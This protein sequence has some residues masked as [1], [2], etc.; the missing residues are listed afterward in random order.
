MEEGI[1]AE[2]DPTFK[3]VDALMPFAYR[4]LLAQVSPSAVA[5]RLERVG[6]TSPSWS[7]T[8]RTSST[9]CSGSSRAADS[10]FTCG[11]RSYSR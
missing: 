9:G 7:R 5:A 8:C 11:R 6:W 2:L 1:A 4:Q 3:L 10:R